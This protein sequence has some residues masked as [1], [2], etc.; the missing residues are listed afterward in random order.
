MLTSYGNTVHYGNLGYPL[1]RHLGLER[2]FSL[3]V[4]CK[5]L[6][7]HHI[8]EDAPK[9]LFVRKYIRLVGKS[10]PSGLDCQVNVL[11]QLS[12]GAKHHSPIYTH[13]RPFSFAI[14]CALKC[15]F[16]VKG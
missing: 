9:M 4:S 10:G 11:A 1:R 16:T 15:F 13:G 8:V 12:Y 2:R 7:A 14:S 5:G 6:C 3:P